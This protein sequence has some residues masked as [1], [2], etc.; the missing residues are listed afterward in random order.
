[1][2]LEPVDPCALKE[3]ID[4]RKRAYRMG[5][6]LNKERRANGTI[7]GVFGAIGAATRASLKPSM[8][9]NI[10]TAGTIAVFSASAYT[11]LDSTYLISVYS[12]TLHAMD[13]LNDCQGL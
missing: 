7:I 4:Y 6:A 3:Q 12:A 13:R 9:R 5:I 2:S 10:I 8:F 1:M 11:I